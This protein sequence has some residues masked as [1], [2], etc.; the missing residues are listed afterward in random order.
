MHVCVEHP[1]AIAMSLAVL[2]WQ[3][4]RRECFFLNRNIGPVSLGIPGKQM[5]AKLFF[6]R[7]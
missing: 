4:L 1:G 6:R 2:F 3:I 7:E 5:I